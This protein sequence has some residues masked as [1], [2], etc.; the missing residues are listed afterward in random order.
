M[1]QPDRRFTAH[2]DLPGVTFTAMQQLLQMQARSND[3]NLID[4]TPDRVTIE[5]RRGQIS[6]RAG[7]YCETSVVVSASSEDRLFMLKSGLISQIEALLPD[8]ARAIHWSDHDMTSNLPPNFTFVRAIT[9]E[10]LG[11]VFLRVTLAG[12]DLSRHG[13]E[14]IHFR[15]VQTPK[16]SPAQW[17]GVAPNGSIIWPDGPN[18]PHR[19]VYTTRLV[20]HDANRL[21]T[22]VFVHE[23]GRTTEW[24]QQIMA[25]ARDREVVGLLGPSGGGLLEADQVLMASDE[26]GFPAAAR[27]L[28]NL[29]ANAIGQ[30]F[31]E[32]EHG[33]D[34]AYPITPPPGVRVTWLS[35]ANGE[36]L[37]DATIRALSDHRQSKIWFAGEKS[38]A[39]RLREA[40]SLAG[41]DRAD[42][43]IS[44][45]WTREV[46]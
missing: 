41:R 34:C 20:D 21:I 6:L 1:T 36:N 44:G 24:A 33:A 14:A 4:D 12:E 29:P 40:A 28:E 9:A 5:T 43:R 13:D 8:L 31:L 22:D 32:A 38:E 2:S 37:A 35:R 23:G 11:P 17:P 39:R 46:L 19:P 42:L 26:T 25:G 18:A 27:L 3:L 16:D 45:F 15:L 7:Q 10:P 30:I